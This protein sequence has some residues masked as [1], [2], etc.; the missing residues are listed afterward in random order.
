MKKVELYFQDCH[1]GTLTYKNNKFVYN[2]DV[3]GEKDFEKVNPIKMGYSLFNS[4]DY[5]GEKIF[6]EFL[7]FVKASERSD[8]IEDGKILPTDDLF[9]KL[10]KVAGVN[11]DKNSFYIRQS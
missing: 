5:C 7:E 10:Y 2:S 11:T 6:K 3:L 8:F 1:L 9:T 4:K